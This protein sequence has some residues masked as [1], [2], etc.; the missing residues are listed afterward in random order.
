ML[1]CDKCNKAFEAGETNGLPNGVGFE[2]A[3]GKIIT[4]CAECI[5]RLGA[6]DQQGRESFIDEL[7]KRKG[8]NL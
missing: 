4:L 8:V 7:A 2:L 1:I 3:N 5:E 6:L